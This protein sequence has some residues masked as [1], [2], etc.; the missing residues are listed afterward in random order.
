MGV[1]QRDHSKPKAGG[2]VAKTLFYTPSR[3]NTAFSNF[4]NLY[5][6]HGQAKEG[7][8]AIIPGGPRHQFGSMDL[9]TKMLV[10]LFH[11]FKLM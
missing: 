3:T 9:H 7:Q 1:F 5:G 10:F 4:S 11:T 8:G 2:V 6:R